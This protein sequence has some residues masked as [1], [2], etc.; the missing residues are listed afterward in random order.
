MRN[1]IVVF[2][3]L[4]M[5]GC[6]SS[7]GTATEPAQES[8]QPAQP[9]PQPTLNVGEKVDKPV[10]LPAVSV[11]PPK[12]SIQRDKVAEVQHKEADAPETRSATIKTSEREFGPYEW[13]TAWAKDVQ[14]YLRP[15]DKACET[16]Q[17]KY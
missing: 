10:A 2:I 16:Q 13:M 3:S 15:W 5:A 4:L 6:A 11:A 12:L 17:Q 1:F 14:Q 8:A 7:S 9:R